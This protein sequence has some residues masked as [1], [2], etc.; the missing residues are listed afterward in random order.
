MQKKHT[1]LFTMFPKRERIGNLSSYFFLT[2]AQEFKVWNIWIPDNYHLVN[3]LL[4]D[5][6]SH[7]VGVSSDIG[8]EKYVADQAK[9]IFVTTR[10][11]FLQG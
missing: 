4:T 7:F 9:L 8:S 3:D 11:F 5:P 2:A 10:A 6:G 1:F